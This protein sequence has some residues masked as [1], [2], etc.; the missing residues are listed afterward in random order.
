[1]LDPRTRKKTITGSST[2]L[3]RFFHCRFRSF[4]VDIMPAPTSKRLELVSNLYM[5]AWK[6]VRKPIYIYIY[7]YN[8]HGKP[9]INIRQNDHTRPD[10]ARELWLWICGG[11]DDFAC[12]KSCLLSCERQPSK[13]TEPEYNWFTNDASIDCRYKL[14]FSFVHSVDVDSVAS[15]VSWYIYI[16][17]WVNCMSSVNWLIRTTA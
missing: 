1:M 17:A 13:S 2:S 14:C 7:I 5:H 16:Y 12:D 4:K 6:K 3:C 9:L 8:Y 11:L 15:W 10:G